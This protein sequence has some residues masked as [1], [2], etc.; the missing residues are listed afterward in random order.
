MRNTHKHKPHHI[1][2][3][4]YWPV[5][6]AVWLNGGGGIIVKCVW[7]CIVVVAAAASAAGLIASTPGRA[8][9]NEIAVCAHA[10]TV[11][12][13]GLFTTSAHEIQAMLCSQALRR[14]VWNV[15]RDEMSET[16]RRAHF[17]YYI[18]ESAAVQ[19]HDA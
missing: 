2:R 18:D 17:L 8:K 9:R 14:D 16:A 3:A 7:P 10:S 6:I 15:R 13:D 11:A 19:T 1:F 5:G 4:V 12:H